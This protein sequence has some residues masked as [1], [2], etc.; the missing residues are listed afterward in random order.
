MKRLAP[1][2]VGAVAA[3][4]FA[5]F[6]G[7][8]INLEDEGLILYQIA[9]TFRGQL[10]Y[11]DFHTGY[12]PG[13]FYLNAGLFH[14]FGESVLPL[15]W[16]LVVI[17]AASV[18]LLFVLARPWGGGA[19][20][21]VAALGYAAFL[22]CFT[23]DFAS[24]NVPYP[25]W[26][27]GLAFLGA[28]WAIDRHLRQGR[29]GALLLAGLMAGVAFSFKP[30]SGVLAVLACGLV[31]AFLAAGEG[32]ADRRPARGLLVLGA[33]FFVLAFNFAVAGPEFA[34]ICGP[35]ILL[36]LG[37][38][39]WARAPE[40]APLR[41][42][43]GV[44]LV[45]AGTLA[46]TLP[47]VV[48][49]LVKLGALGFLR[50]VLLVGSDA[51]RIYATPYPVPIGFPASWPAVVAVGL[52][53]AGVLGLGAE[54]GRLRLGRAVGTL[55]L[56]AGGSL[57]LLAAWARM[58]EGV[59]RS[60]VWQAQHVG[61]VLVP[62]M[63]L[64]TSA[65]LLRRLRGA[66]GQLGIEGRR[67]M[68]VLIFAYASFVTLYPRVDTMHLIVAMP[69]ALVLAV[70]CTARMARAWSVVLGWPR[71]LLT[72]GLVAGGAA[73]AMVA[74]LPNYAGLLARPQLALAT[75]RAP[76]HVE[77]ERGHDFE[78]LNAVLEHL[79]TR[80][81]PGEP[82]FAYPALALIPFALGHPTPTPHDYFF[83]GRPDH[84][85]EVEIV[86][87]LE[88]APPRYVVTLNRRL[89]FF[90]ESPAYYFILRRWLAQH[91]RLD[92]RLGRYDV[93]IRRD[94]PVTPPTERTF[95]DAPSTDALLVEM[96]DPDRERRGAA[97]RA[98]LE[99]AGTAEGI[100]P[101]AAQVAP[102][103]PSLLLLLRNLG[104]AGDGRAVDFLVD[105]FRAGEWRV[106][107]D[108]A[109]ALTYLALRES[110]ERYLPRDDPN[111]P[112][113]LVL[114]DHLGHVPR[115]EA[116]QWM[117]D[118]KLRLQVGVF[119][120]RALATLD[121]REAIPVF[122]QAFAE[123]AKRPYLQV[124]AAEGLVRFGKLERLCDLVG[125][126]AQKK[127][128][129]QDAV[130]SFLIEMSAVHPREVTDCLAAGLGSDQPLERETS[131]WIA[132]AAHIT[133]LGPALVP[134]L[135]DKD[136]A[137]RLAAI[138]ALGTLDDEQARARLV[139]LGNDHDPQVRAFATEALARMKGGAA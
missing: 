125:M 117:S 49:F 73:L 34:V 130:P 95:I 25:S 102:D 114:R 104:E 85:A 69:S 139:E 138:W 87:Q 42:W 17:N 22:P 16:A 128:E 39:F 79:G 86:R 107:G 37:R 80:L 55:L 47:W 109:N 108:A 121:D 88:A 93:L 45:A 118:L 133:A 38:L 56:V 9:R 1:L 70:A 71:R 30:N 91:Y 46:V 19:L 5:T 54:H 20:A 115:A 14:L 90:S 77:A 123:E 43:Q 57:S 28:Q 99:R 32:D 40:H 135:D 136:H 18:A 8:G 129:I 4:Y 76:V 52:V 59:V 51:D 11:V 122:E 10:P 75:T 68:A 60:I 36:L 64:A 21:A 58:P 3:L 124:V 120:G 29:G 66:D 116:R 67:L 134:L 110:N 103:E 63:G 62:L 23:G 126:L 92:A 33:L 111:A 113:G 84:V 127:H 98:F 26:Y 101:L 82:L 112:G 119:A 27:A 48:P 35:P 106:R 83:P 13:T 74:S 24:F 100:A 131:A 53:T 31:L 50:E 132:G 12:T 96:G 97:T 78:A 61:F 105:T 15:R 6:V 41:L 72:G 65:H 89:G 2:V 81:R 137:A 7:Y 44:G 94:Q